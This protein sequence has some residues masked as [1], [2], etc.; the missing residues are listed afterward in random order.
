MSD[1][2]LGRME[3]I[4]GSQRIRTLIQFY[5]NGF[6]LR[7]L[8]KLDTLNS[9]KF[10]D[11]PIHLQRF[12]INQDFRIIVVDDAQET[13]RQ[14]LFERIN[15]TSEGLT[16]SEIRKGSFSGSFYDC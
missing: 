8:E 11:L 5:N 6:S 12:L 7:K 10:K 16:D 14:D 1:T 15:T 9:A 2:E 3:I 4:D 13:I